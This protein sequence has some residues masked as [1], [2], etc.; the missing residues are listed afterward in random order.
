MATNLSLSRR[1]EGIV[2][3]RLQTNFS[4]ADLR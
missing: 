2:T 1:Y 4:H 3:N